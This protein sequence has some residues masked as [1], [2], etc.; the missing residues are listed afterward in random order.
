MVQS[1]PS[2]MR[3]PR[4]AGEG[5][6]DFAEAPVPAPGPGQLLLKVS[7]NALCGS[8]RGQ[9]RGGSPVTPGHEAA[10]IVVEAG[11]E[12]H[13]AT[14]TSGAVYLMD[15]CQECRSCRLGYTNQCLA[16]RGD[17]GFNRD[18]GY[19][20]YELIPEHLFFPVGPELSG[21]EATMLLDVMGTSSHAIGRARLVRPDVES[22]LIT[23]AGP[24]GLGVLAMA[25]V[26]LGE[27]I[28]ILITDVSPY[29]LTLAE[30][31]GGIPIN[32]ERKNLPD[33]V[34]ARASG[35]VDAAVDT[36]GR[37][38]ARGQALA[39]LGKRGVLVCVGHRQG[40]T[41]DVSRD[42]I[43]SERTVMGSEYFRFDEFADNLERL[44]VHRAYFGQVITHRFP[45]DRISEAFETFYAGET[46]KV[47]VEH[48]A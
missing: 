31:L 22:L 34:R 40:L 43:A 46:G 45:L 1:P 38:E 42:L 44:H 28:P 11:P 5:R 13:T 20:P 9:Y 21:A 41:L 33:A 48:D 17:M 14:G 3:V 47:I 10:G 16:K 23:G 7:A 8:E 36:S 39:A 27:S 4:F 24:V 37:E 35:A 2:T 12:T 30:R 26:M 19:A 15:Y 29:R 32:V 25:R 6:I 18:G